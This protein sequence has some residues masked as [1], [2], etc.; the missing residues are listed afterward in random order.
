MKQTVI[1][2]NRDF[3]YSNLGNLEK[4]LADGW[5]VVFVNPI[6]SSLEYILQKNN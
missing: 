2:T 1:R 4:L 3:N 5:V 6:G